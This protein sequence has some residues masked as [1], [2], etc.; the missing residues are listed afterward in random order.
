MYIYTY[1]Y[2]NSTLHS[3]KIEKLGIFDFKDSNYANFT[4]ST[5][6]QIGYKS[7][8]SV[9]SRQRLQAICKHT[10]RSAY[11]ELL[12]GHAIMFILQGLH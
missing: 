3:L 6:L 12:V 9:Y 8:I 11:S 4:S 2:F 1:A 7:V 10:V 5:I